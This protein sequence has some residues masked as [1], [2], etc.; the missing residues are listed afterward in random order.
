[1][2]RRWRRPASRWWNSNAISCL[3]PKLTCARFAASVREK[4]ETSDTRARK[5]LQQQ[6]QIDEQRQAIVVPQHANTVR[7][8]FRSLLEQIFFVDGIGADDFVGGD[9]EANVFVRCLV[10]QDGDD[11]VLRQ[12]PGAAAFG[13]GDI[14][15]RND[16]AA[17]IENSYEIRGTEG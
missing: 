1:M 11:H 13:H 14:D 6:P 3:P 4:I 16:G 8:I 2:R 7:N 12:K 15:E 9:A 5:S 10:V 17:E